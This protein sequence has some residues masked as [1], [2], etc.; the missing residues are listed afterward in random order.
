MLRHRYTACLVTQNLHCLPSELH[1]SHCV[2]SSL[3]PPKEN[4]VFLF[5]QSSEFSES[6]E[7]NLTQL[8]LFLLLCYVPILSEAYVS[9]LCQT[10][11]I[12]FSFFSIS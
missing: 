11:F 5:M 6:Y 8:K 2:E 10:N 7:S 4:T 3:Q 9:L 1:L 12:S